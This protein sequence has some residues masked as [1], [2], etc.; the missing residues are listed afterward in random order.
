MCKWKKRKK[1]R[2]ERSDFVGETTKPTTRN[3]HSS[4]LLVVTK[5]PSEFLQYR[6]EERLSLSLSLLAPVA[7]KVLQGL[8]RKKKRVSGPLAAAM[9]RTKDAPRPPSPTPSTDSFSAPAGC[10][11]CALAPSRE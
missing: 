2:T 3:E 10:P 6:R 7:Y 8:P 9:E 5:L 11:L 4:A 1:K